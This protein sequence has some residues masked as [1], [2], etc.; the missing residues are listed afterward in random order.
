[1]WYQLASR[2]CAHAYA[3]AF[4]AIDGLCVSQVD[5]GAGEQRVTA[6][7]CRSELFESLGDA[8]AAAAD[9][10]LAAASTAT[11]GDA[12]KAWRVAHL[13]ERAASLSARQEW[14]MAAAAYTRVLCESAMETD[15]RLGRAIA[16][17]CLSRAEHAMAD[18]LL[19]V[20]AGDGGGAQA[21][22]ALEGIIQILIEQRDWQAVASWSEK[23]RIVNSRNEQA[24]AGLAAA[25]AANAADAKAADAVEATVADVDVAAATAARPIGRAAEEEIAQAAAAQRLMESRTAAHAAA[26]AVDSGND[27][28]DASEFRIAIRES[29]RLRS[30]ISSA[31]LDGASASPGACMEAAVAGTG[32]TSTAAIVAEAQSA[33]LTILQRLLLQRPALEELDAEL[34]AALALCRA[35]RRG[36]RSEPTRCNKALEDSA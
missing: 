6:L 36:G 27:E 15:A 17:H 18:F 13:K 24:Q 29:Q 14:A 35:G 21:E 16:R 22:A 3:R 12:R 5:I 11:G 26:H 2:L 7:S 4:S 31:F 25:A 19:V 34:N 10:R 33:V 20:A 8:R 1:M 28:S 32:P 23:L 9:R 30:L